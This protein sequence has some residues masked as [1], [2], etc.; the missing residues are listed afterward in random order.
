[1]IAMVYER[2]L[3]HG[4]SEH[5]PSR[6]AASAGHPCRWGCWESIQTCLLTTN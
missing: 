3:T 4:E 2:G 5:D 6:L 1:M